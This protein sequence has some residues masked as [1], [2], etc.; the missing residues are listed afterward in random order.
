MC[1]DSH[2]TE[3]YD[4]HMTCGWQQIYKMADGGNMDTSRPLLNEDISEEANDVNVNCA[5]ERESLG[6]GTV[7]REIFAALSSCVGTLAFGYALAFSS[8]ASTDYAEAPYHLSKTELSWFGSIVALGAMAGGVLS[9]LLID[10]LG[11]KLCSMTTG[12]PFCLGWLLILMANPKV[13]NRELFVC[14]LYAG[15]LVTGIGAGMQT[16]CAPVYVSEVSST[17]MRGVLGSC[18]QLMVTIGILLTNVFS[19]WMNVYWLAV[20][21]EFVCALYVVLMF[22]MPETPRWLLSKGNKQAALQS[23]R[24][25]RGPDYNIERE[26]WQ[27][28]EALQNLPSSVSPRELLKRSVFIPLMMMV[29]VMVFQ[30]FSG[31]NSVIFYT[32]TIFHEAG[33]TWDPIYASILVTGIQ[34]AATGAAC[35]LMDRAGRRILLLLA[36][37]FMA[38]SAATLG[39]YYYMSDVKN[40]NHDWISIGSLVIYIIFFSLGWGPVPWLYMGE[41]FPTNVKGMAGGIATVVNWTCAFIITYSFASMEEGLNKYGTFWLYAGICA[42]SG[43]FVVLV[44]PETK[45]KSLDEITEY[46]QQGKI[47]IFQR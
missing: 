30:Q 4:G 1:Y 33:I 16:V 40:V 39:A 36:S 21:G 46:F 29:A 12:I 43:V 14:L 44:L 32:Q 25:L 5:P 13:M 3:H 20:A 2:V 10:R 9:A 37:I 19:I 15:R 23:I 42:L 35:A 17:D 24:W 11:R 41:L 28:E 7:L 18:V 8:P 34:V 26:C 27:T 6:Q 45:G 22:F 31:I 47:F 38:L